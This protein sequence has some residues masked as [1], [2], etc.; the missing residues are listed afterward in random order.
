MVTAQN[1]QEYL[2]DGEILI[3]IRE[4]AKKRTWQVRFRNP[5]ADKPRYIRESTKTENKSLAIERAIAKY[6]DYQSRQFL[7]LT[8]GHLTISTLLDMASSSLSDIDYQMAET[9]NRIY[10]S[11]YMGEDDISKW[12]SSDWKKYFV[13]RIKEQV[14]RPEGSYFKPSEHSVSVSSLK[15]E[16]VLLQKLTRYGYQH[17]MIARLPVFPLK[18]EA[19]A[20]GAVHKLPSNNRRG[21]F[22]D[23]QYS[24]ILAPEFRRIRHQLQRDENTP[25]PFRPREPW[26]KEKNPYISKAKRMVKV[27]VQKRMEDPNYKFTCKRPRY[28][29]AQFWF[30]S[31]LIANTGIRPAEVVKLKHEDFSVREDP[32][33]G[34]W[35]T[36]IRI[37][38][39]TSKIGKYREVIARDFHQTW[40]RYQLFK[41]ETEY[42]FNEEVR[43][44][45]WLLPRSWKDG[46]LR[47]D[48]PVDRLNNIFRPHMKRLGLHKTQVQGVQVYYSAY[49][50][51]AFYI[52]KRLEE[53]LNIYTLSKNAGVSIQTIMSTYDYSENWAYRDEMTKH[54]KALKDETP[55]EDELVALRLVGKSWADNINK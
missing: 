16:R 53:G 50:F 54:F 52:T 1:E 11:K 24:K 49:S 13:W 46:K 26:D 45:D 19:L 14:N 35:Y 51:R 33:D 30:V 42:Y 48:L 21:R 37:T 7:G 47:Y 41:K 3:Y 28:N 5:L 39:E 23:E 22:T 10:W 18:F 43:E 4:G 6:R 12:R 38:R 17:D 9:A 40:E 25:K 20:P 36:I 31:L 34:R 8:S 32:N 55:S 15:L 29:H 27:D 44:G 2:L